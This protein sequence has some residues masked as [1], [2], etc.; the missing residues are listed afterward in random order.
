MR[1]WWASWF[2]SERK[3]ASTTPSCTNRD[4]TAPPDLASGSRPHPTIRPFVRVL[5]RTVPFERARPRTKKRVVTD[6]ICVLYTTLS[7]KPVV[8][9]S[10]SC[11]RIIPRL[12]WL[13]PVSLFY[14]TVCQYQKVPKV[15]SGQRRRG[16][17][18]LESKRDGIPFVS[19][20]LLLLPLAD[21]SYRHQP[22][23]AYGQSGI[24]IRKSSPIIRHRKVS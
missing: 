17:R 4:I 21:S 12:V 14:C 22:A 15:G 24:R 3:R 6:P 2:T 11:K 9:V 10:F 13:E 18:S 19:F 5:S 16:G 7:E 8:P 1:V 20:F 23:M